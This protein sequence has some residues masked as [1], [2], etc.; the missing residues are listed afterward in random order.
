MG[1]IIPF[2]KKDE[3]IYYFF[4]INFDQYAMIYFPD[5]KQ[6]SFVGIEEGEEEDE[7]HHIELTGEKIQEL[8][9]DVYPFFFLN[10]KRQTKEDDAPEDV[11]ARYALL[12]YFDFENKQYAV[13][14]NEAIEAGLLLFRIEDKQ[15][16][17]I[18][19]DIENKRVSNFVEDVFEIEWLY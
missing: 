11:G 19:N 14:Y 18:E 13:Y 16:K 8:F 10:V 6:I 12:S 7:L 5:D 2:K 1:D 3:M 15:V 9:D 4:N 17:P